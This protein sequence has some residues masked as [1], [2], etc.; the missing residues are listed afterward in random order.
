MK[1]SDSLYTMRQMTLRNI[2]IFLKDRAAVFF[3]LLA[4][5]I[6]LMLY[7]LFLGDIQVSSVKSFFPDETSL[8]ERAIRSF[9]DSWMI[10]GVLS[11][12]CITV[13]LGANS[14]MVQDRSRGVL[15]DSLS[16]PVK[17][18]VITAGYF[19]ANFLV[20]LVICLIVFAVCLAYL[21]LTGGFCLTA[22]DLLYALGVML[23]S[24]LSATVLTVFIAGFF[25]TESALSAFGGIVSAAIGFLI[26]AYMPMSVFPKA[27]QYFACIFPGSHSAGLFRTCLMRGALEELGTSLPEQ[28]IAGLREG[29]SM[30]LNLFG[31]EVGAPVMW[32]V[33]AASVAVFAALNLLFAFKSK[34]R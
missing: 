26:G 19:A 17:R 4:P 6:V 30:E 34:R 7:I 18:W 3:S 11:V 10:A 22:A 25:R 29:F 5:L 24:I 20:T 13:S 23:L 16:S 12:S 8:D 9:V 31:A 21:A 14:V 1:F 2:K 27:V 15:Y 28:A 32:A 33:L